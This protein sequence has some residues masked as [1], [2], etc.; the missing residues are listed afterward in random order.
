[1]HK[2]GLLVATCTC[3]ASMI[4]LCVAMPPKC[5]DAGKLT[6]VLDSLGRSHLSWLLSGQ[7]SV[8]SSESIAIS[9]MAK[10]SVMDDLRLLLLKFNTMSLYY[11]HY[12]VLY[13]QRLD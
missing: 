1:M 9:L 4:V 13:C 10:L 12:R 5:I 8:L 2:F 11:H 6:K 3:L 7:W